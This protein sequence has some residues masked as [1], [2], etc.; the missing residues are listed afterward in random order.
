MKVNFDLE[1]YI[2]VKD[3]IK[4][5]NYRPCNEGLCCFL[6]N[7][8]KKSVDMKTLNDIVIFHGL[9]KGTSENIVNS[10]KENGIKIFD[11]HKRCEHLEVNININDELVINTNCDDY[12]NRP[13]LC[14]KYPVDKCSLDNYFEPGLKKNGLYL[15][16][17]IFYGFDINHFQELQ[18]FSVGRIKKII[19]NEF[20]SKEYF[21]IPLPKSVNPCCIQTDF[22]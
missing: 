21:L 22:S 8:S 16:Y 15:N 5:D 20:R 2:E 11:S 12:V 13:N 17:L 10:I 3:N 7:K 6:D 19:F 4:I 14:K 1:K 9:V 18:E